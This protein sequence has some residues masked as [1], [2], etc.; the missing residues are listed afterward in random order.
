MSF[1][2]VSE[3]DDGAL[4]V[5]S[6]LI[7]ERLGI[8]HE[9]FLR[10]ID[11][12]QTQLE[13]AFGIL[14][15]EIGK[16]QGRGRP[17]RYAL[18]TED[19]ATF[20]MTLSR[21]TAQVVQ[22]KIELVQAFSKAKELL[23]QREPKPGVLPY[24][25]ERMKIALS[26][27]ERPLPGG[28]FCVYQEIMGL[29]AELEVKLGYLIADIDPQ[30]QKHL[31]PDISIGKRFNEFLRSED[32]MQSKAR[33]YFLGSSEPIDFRQART[34]KAQ[35]GLPAGKHYNEI[36]YYNHVYPK[37]SHGNYQ[38]QSAT[39]YPDKYLELFRHF[40]QEWWIPDFCLSYLLP[41]DPSGLIAAQQRLLQM[42]PMQREMLH[43]TQFGKLIP[44]LL[45][46]KPGK[47]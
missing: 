13:Q 45:S 30:T 19:Q 8:E 44:L 1:L 28:F 9:S 14:R 33:A 41:R 29:F 5:D 42:S 26:D 12:Y 27:T 34:S 38:T 18:L 24:W 17:S 37:V 32:E 47:E 20:L 36:R 23:K 11:T 21:N 46:L 15:F 22:C 31:V 7:A 35:G 6:R 40:L 4:V 16:I 3:Y 2:S 39:A 10:T 43:E 25:Y